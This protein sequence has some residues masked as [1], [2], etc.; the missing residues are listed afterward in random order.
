L[1]PLFDDDNFHTTTGALYESI[2]CLSFQR[3]WNSGVH[4]QPRGYETE[5]E[6][7]RCH[8]NLELPSYEKLC[9]YRD[10]Q[11]F[12][13]FY[14]QTLHL[15]FPIH[16]Q[17]HADSRPFATWKQ[18]RSSSKVLWRTNPQ[19][20]HS[21]DFL[22]LQRPEYEQNTTR[23]RLLVCSTNRNALSNVLRMVGIHYSRNLTKTEWHYPTYDMAV[24]MNFEHHHLDGATNITV[25]TD[26]QTPERFCLTP[27]LNEHQTHRLISFCPTIFKFSLKRSIESA[28]GLFGS[29]RPDHLAGT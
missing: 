22:T 8:S 4:N 1:V 7:Y 12:I 11:V 17:L 20:C 18:T 10:V 25:L 2:K 23:N 6:T 29:R 19:I 15:C 26:H 16:H 3:N 13:G 9:C 27:N 21:P 14:T 5:S 24:V 28:D